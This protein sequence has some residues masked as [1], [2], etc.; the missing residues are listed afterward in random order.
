MIRRVLNAY[1]AMGLFALWGL[2]NF[3]A[4]C[5]YMAFLMIAG[6][7]AIRGMLS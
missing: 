4:G 3:T 6:E 1:K 5:L 2:A 7:A